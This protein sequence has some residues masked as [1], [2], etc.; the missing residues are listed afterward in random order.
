MNEYLQ[1]TEKKINKTSNLLLQDELDGSLEPASQDNYRK[2]E[3]PICL[4]FL[5]RKLSSQKI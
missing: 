2:Q 4:V 1:E 5:N 3:N